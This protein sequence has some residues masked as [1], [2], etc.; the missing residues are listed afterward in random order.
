MKKTSVYTGR[1]NGQKHLVR[2]KT[3]VEVWEISR[4]S[5]Q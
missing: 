3:V 5:R 4:H 1:Y 2:I